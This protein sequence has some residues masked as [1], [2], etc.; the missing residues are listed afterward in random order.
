MVYTK[1]LGEGTVPQDLKLANVASV[2]KKESRS[3]AGNY[4]SVSLTFV[5]CKVME[6]ILRDEIVSLALQTSWST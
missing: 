2:Y 4:R 5:L 3:I 1:S 6:S